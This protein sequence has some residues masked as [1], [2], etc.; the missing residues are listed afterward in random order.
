M[1][2]EIVL[3]YGFVAEL[4]MVRLS[5]NLPGRISVNCHSS[6]LFAWML[7]VVI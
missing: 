1:T 3:I 2:L 6:D 4:W 5:W 7:V